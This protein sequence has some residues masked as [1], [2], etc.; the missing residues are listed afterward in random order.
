MDPD[1][2]DA[3]GLPPFPAG[4]AAA[5]SGS[6]RLALQLASHF[7]ACDKRLRCIGISNGNPRKSK[8]L[9]YKVFFCQTNWGPEIPPAT[10]GE[11][12]HS[13]ELEL[14]ER[15][16]QSDLPATVGSRK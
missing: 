8:I 6:L 16:D 5:L 4:T 2:L 13:L 9:D 15:R 7:L 11:L 3:I 14:G 10:P 12:T 1:A